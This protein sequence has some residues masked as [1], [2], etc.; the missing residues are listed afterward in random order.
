MGFASELE[1][2]QRRGRGRFVRFQCEAGGA[3]AGDE[4]WWGAAAAGGGGNWRSRRVLGMLVGDVG[5][6]GSVPCREG[7]AGLARA[8]TACTCSRPAANVSARSCCPKSAPTC[9]SAAPNATAC[10]WPPASLFTPSTWALAARTRAEQRVRNRMYRPLPDGRGSVA[11]RMYW[12]L[13]DGRGSVAFRAAPHWGGRA[14]RTPFRITRWNNPARSTRITIGAL[15]VD[16]HGQS[17]CC[18]GGV[19][20]VPLRPGG[21]RARYRAG[22]RGA[23]HAQ[24]PRRHLPAICRS[25]YRETRRAAGDSGASPEPD[26]RAHSR[27]D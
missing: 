3:V 16:Q 12:P 15:P 4:P 21:A 1:L 25:G 9:V 2:E 14:L 27:R 11:F 26:P 6:T 7:S 18:A 22:L 20:R 8:M 23:G 5:Q 24:D 19:R 17:R 10:S 13:P